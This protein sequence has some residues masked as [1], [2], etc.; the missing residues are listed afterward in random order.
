MNCSSV[1]Q[2]VNLHSYNAVEWY[3]H[4]VH[5]WPA[6]KR[7]T[8]TFFSV[9]SINING[10]Y[11]F[12]VCH[13]VTILVWN[14]NWVISGTML[15]YLHNFLRWRCHLTNILIQIH[16][17]THFELF[18][19]IIT[20]VLDSLFIYNTSCIH[21]NYI[22]WKYRALLIHLVSIR[23]LKKVYILKTLWRFVK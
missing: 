5:L 13:L 4:V 10:I 14:L 23:S 16:F 22:L 2:T 21:E 8:F 15:L 20:T 18:D 12:G 19:S 17:M 3:L 9:Y 11:Y 7:S 1:L 6:N